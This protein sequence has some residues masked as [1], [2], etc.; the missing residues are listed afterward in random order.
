LTPTTTTRAPAAA[1]TAFR[2]S[3]G[4]DIVSP[5]DPGWDDARLAWNLAVDQQPTVIAFPETTEH[6]VLLVD[7]AR[8]QGL[9]V[10]PQGTG[11]AAGA[12]ESLDHTLLM[13]TE[14]MRDVEIDPVARTARVVAGVQWAEVT[15]AAAEHGL[16]ALAGS[17]PDVGVVGYTLGGGISFLARR[18]GLASNSVTAIELVTA[19]GRLVRTDG[20]VEPDLFWALRGGGGSFGAVTAIEFELYPVAEVYAGMLAFPI[21]RA[22]E[23]LHA[24]C[25]WTET[26]PDEVSS[27]GRLLRIPP[28]PEIPE[29]V[30]GRKLVVIQAAILKYEAEA[31]TLLEP[32]RALGPD[33]DTFG[34]VPATAL[35]HLHMDP[36]HPVAARSTGMLLRTL[37][38][39]AVDA[40]VAVAGAAAQVPLLSIEVRHLGGALAR[41]EPHHGAGGTIEAEFGM[42]G[43]GMAMNPEMKAAIDAY[44]PRLLAAL[45]PNQAERSYMNFEDGPTDASTLFT[46][47]TFELLREVKARHDPG[48]MFRSN[49]PIPLG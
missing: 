41:P 9:R 26:I 19:D 36:E 18:Y 8:D 24:W 33:I 22:S 15:D 39:E 5:A 7:F 38:P 12:H 28:L 14:R 32:L 46:A 6:V 10:A 35:K 2:A 1:V 47:R 34:M 40:L 23:V 29:I 27:T 21:E 16:A 43:V 30:R 13:K 48:D 25:D 17:S 4:I 11:H 44:A 3:T 42:F 31:A 49:H 37:P 20:Y 45:A